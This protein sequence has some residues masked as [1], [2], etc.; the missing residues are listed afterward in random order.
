[1]N[2]R[3]QKEIAFGKA[4]ISLSKNEEIADAKI[5]LQNLIDHDI[6]EFI[7]GSYKVPIHTVRYETIEEHFSL[8]VSQ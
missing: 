5:V 2:K 3:L 1:M 6:V 8:E 4:I 7:D